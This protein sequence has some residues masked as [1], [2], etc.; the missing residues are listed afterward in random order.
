MAAPAC[1]RVKKAPRRLMSI[2]R[3]HSDAGRATTGPT[4]P[5]PADAT[6]CWRPPLASVAASTA[7]A[8][9]SSWATSHATRPHL[10]AVGRLGL[11]LGDGAVEPLL[12]PPGERDRRAVAQQVPSGGQP[13]AAAPA[14]DQPGRAGQDE[15]AHLHPPRVGEAVTLGGRER[16]QERLGR[17]VARAPRGGGRRRGPR[18]RSAPA[19]RCS[20]ARRVT[21]SRGPGARPHRRVPS[22]GAAVVDQLERHLVG[23]AV[24]WP[25]RCRTS[26]PSRRNRDGTATSPVSCTRHASTLVPATAVASQAWAPI[27]CRARSCR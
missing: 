10:G 25:W 15:L 3:S 22:R 18:A 26:P 24:P 17:G 21:S 20:G 27:G 23:P 5:V 6:Q 8:T 2:T 7:R 9:S 4:V 1:L 19:D 14:G 12:A 11:Q 13:D 16:G